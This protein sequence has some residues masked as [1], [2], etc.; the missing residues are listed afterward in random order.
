MKRARISVCPLGPDGA[1]ADL[2]GIGLADGT[3]I[4]GRYL[5]G[6]ARDAAVALGLVA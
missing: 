5:D 3:L 1:H 2:R 6:L 4:S